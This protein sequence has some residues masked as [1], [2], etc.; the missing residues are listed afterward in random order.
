M[1]EALPHA[2]RFLSCFYPPPRE[3]VLSHAWSAAVRLSP[4]ATCRKLD[5][6]RCALPRDWNHDRN[7]SND[8]FSLTPWQKYHIESLPQP[9]Y[10]LIHPGYPTKALTACHEL[11]LAP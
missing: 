10:R 9:V 5:G 2:A 7:L 6:T 4:N 11:P 8:R 3:I 1:N